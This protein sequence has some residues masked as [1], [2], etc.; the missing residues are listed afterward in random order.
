VHVNDALRVAVIIGVP[1]GVVVRVGLPVVVKD[2]EIESMGE[3]VPEVVAVMLIAEWVAEVGVTLLENVDEPDND[4]ECDLE[5]RLGETLQVA[6]GEP[7]DW[8]N[9]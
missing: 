2:W 5:W 4:S 7:G 8:V 9:E 1:V 3:P 6:V